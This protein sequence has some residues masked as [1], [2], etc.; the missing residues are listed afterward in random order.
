MQEETEMTQITIQ[1]DDS[2]FK[3][4]ETAAVQ[5]HTSVSKWIEKRILQELK[6]EWPEN[7]FSLFG[8]L[9][10]DDLVEPPEIPFEYD[11]KRENL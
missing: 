7:Y 9:D 11:S 5:S 4:L 2:T 8:S 10:E 3:A 6:H 1:L